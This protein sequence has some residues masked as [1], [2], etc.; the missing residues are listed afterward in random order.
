MGSMNVGELI[1][2]VLGRLIA[3]RTDTIFSGVSID[4]RSVRKNELFF[5]IVGKRFDGHDFVAEAVRRGAGGAVVSRERAVGGSNGDVAVVVVDD[6]LKALQDVAGWHRRRFRCPVAAITGSNGKTTT[7]DLTWAILSRRWRTLRAEGSKNNH[8]GLPLTLAALDDDTDAAVVELG[9]SNFGEIRSL[10]SICVPDV[11]C[12]TNVGAAHLEFFG[13]VE[14]VARAK[15]E[16]L[17]GMRE[18][19]PV[20]L[21]ADD[22][23]YEWLRARAKGPVV[24]FGIR[25]PADFVAEDIVARNGVVVFR[26]RANLWGVQ[27][28]V[29]MPVAGAHN[30]YNALASAAIS[31]QLGAGI[32]DIEEGLNKAS[33]PSMR[34][35][36]SKFSGV[37]VINDA[38]NANPVSMM[39]S[40]SS[41]C[42]M[43]IRGK[44][45]FVCGDMLELGK[46]ADK[47][48]KELGRFV[49][50]KP[51][52]YVVA[53]GELAPAVAEAAFG[54]SSGNGR[55]SC[56][57]SVEEVV[58]V[59]MKLVAPGDAV[60]IKGSRANAMERIVGALRAKMGETDTHEGWFGSRDES[61]AGK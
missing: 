31:S 21:N 43:G 44:R 9:T 6:T 20:V 32:F 60:L 59:L 58:S 46:Y 2:A 54:V 57:R 39:S 7:K 48:H 26:M 38:Y 24:T 12:I 3:G 36:M 29:E 51:I 18:G 45:I 11:G 8:V 56:C 28:R 34:Y 41:F 16:L 1:N 37:A 53:F 5:A 30:A 49:K 55:S 52:D 35:E 15:A 13:S 27:R 40:V 14:N 33:L 25:R 17:E 50:T 19:C 10:V 23:W 22:E 4:S 47:F 61:R 42:E